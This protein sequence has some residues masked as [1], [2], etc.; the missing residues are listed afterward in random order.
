[1]VG[2]GDKVGFAPTL[3][4]A[5]DQVFGGDSGA[6]TASNDGNKNAPAAKGKTGQPA[7]KAPSAQEKL[8]TALQ[9]AKKAMADADSAMKAGDWTKYGEAQKSLND[10]ISRAVAAQDEGAKT[11]K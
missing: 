11:A 5:L 8:N 7:A 3:K 2:F 4:E 6:V 9:D 10:A 1:M